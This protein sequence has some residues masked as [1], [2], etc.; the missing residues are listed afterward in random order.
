MQ[1]MTDHYVLEAS[2][3]RLAD[4]RREAD[5]FRLTKVLA[6]QHA[7]LFPHA[8]KFGAGVLGLVAHPATR[9]P[10]V[11]RGPQPCPC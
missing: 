2:A 10:T 3:G 11:A 6:D 5:E 8:R 7:R 9:R 4:L 1:P